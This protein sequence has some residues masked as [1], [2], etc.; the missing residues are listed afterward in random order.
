MQ[1]LHPLDA[2]VA[3]LA[4]RL[5]LA[6]EKQ[7]AVAVVRGDVIDNLARGDDAALAAEP[8]E[9]FGLTVQTT[10]SLPAL[11]VVKVLMLRRV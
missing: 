5:K 1:F 8:A 10:Q 9:R 6:Q 11:S 7:I 4:E 2:V 3:I